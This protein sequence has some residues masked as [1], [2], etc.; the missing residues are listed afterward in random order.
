MRPRHSTKRKQPNSKQHE[1]RV[2]T[3][4]AGRRFSIRRNPDGTRSAEGYF[5]TFGTLSHK[6]P[7]REVLLKGCFAESLRT[8]AVACLKDHNW[9]QLLG[10][11]QNNTLSVAEDGKGLR[12]VVKLPDG[13]SYSD[14]LVALMERGDATECSFA[15]TVDPSDPDAEEWSQLPNGDILRSIKRCTVYEGS[16]LTGAPAAFPNTEAVLRSL[17]CPAEIKAALRSKITKRDEDDDSDC[18]PDS[19]D[20]PDACEDEEDRDECDCACDQCEDGYCEG[21]S[22]MNCESDRCIRCAVQER[23]LHTS[24]ILRRLRS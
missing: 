18:D 13:V 20:Y 10:K 6:L 5:A 24:L 15:F 16:I 7:W 4:P 8:Q 23:E 11:S 3:Q 1:I 14:D 17:S 9:E 22:N 12:F 2:C 21:C 19:P